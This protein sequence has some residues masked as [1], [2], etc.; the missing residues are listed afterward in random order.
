MAAL[1]AQLEVETRALIDR[2]ATLKSK[3][4]EAQDRDRKLSL[5][6]AEESMRRKEL[7]DGRN[8]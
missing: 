5:R 8:W 2:D 4:G 1:R 3:E 7:G 6:E